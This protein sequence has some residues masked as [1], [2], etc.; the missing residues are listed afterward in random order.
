MKYQILK[1]YRVNI[2]WRFSLNHVSIWNYPI[3][4]FKDDGKLHEVTRFEDRIMIVSEGMI[5]ISF[6]GRQCNTAPRRPI[7]SPSFPS[8][9]LSPEV[10]VDLHRIE[11]CRCA[12]C[13]VTSRRSR[14][15]GG[16]KK[17]EK[18]NWHLEKFAIDASMFSQLEIPLFLSNYIVKQ[19]YLKY[20]KW[21]ILTILTK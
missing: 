14:F 5:R 3:P 8:A 2:A 21:Y 11:N 16:E 13:N 12:W 1:I 19:K 15:T 20:L 10:Y 4:K 7:L 18:Y 6:F 9:L 17:K